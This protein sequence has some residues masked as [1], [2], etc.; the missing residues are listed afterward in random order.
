MIAILLLASDGSSQVVTITING[1]EDAP[2]IG[3][4]D[5]GSV[6]EDLDPDADTLLETGGVL[7]IADPDTGESSFVAETITGTYGDL[8]IDAPGNWTYSADNTQA[9]IQNLST[10]DILVDTISV[11]SFDGTTHNIVITI[12]G[13]NDAPTTVDDNPAA[14]D[15]GG[16][17]IFDLAA[18][19]FDIDNAIDLNSI[20]IT[21]APA[22]GSLIVNS[23]GT[24]TYT[25][26]GSETISDSFSY[27][28][29]DVTG[30][31]SNIA[32]VNIIVNP[33][34]DP[35]SALDDAQVVSEGGTVN[36]KLVANDTDIDYALI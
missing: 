11:T 16:A 32:T 12:G 1:A 2:L 28:I 27:T 13:V 10:P 24:V 9:A 20:S 18:N 35:P 36:V 29:E 7:T 14:V 17:A 21:A 26:D 23:N 31:I 4:V 34:N 8:T 25:H 19:D 3:G 5:T 22:N 15:E 30:A 33:V 6:T